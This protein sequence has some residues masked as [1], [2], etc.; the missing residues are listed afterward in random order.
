MNNELLAVLRLYLQESL[1]LQEKK[2]KKYKK[3][4]KDQDGDGNITRKDVLLAR[5]VDLDES[6]GKIRCPNCSAMNERTRSN[7]Y[8]C[9]ASLASVKESLEEI[10]GSMIELSE[11]KR[12]K[13]KASDIPGYRS[14]RNKKQLKKLDQ[15]TKK[16]AAGKFKKSD[17]EKEDRRRQAEKKKGEET[18]KNRFSNM[19]G[20][21]KE[22]L[23]RAELRFL[24]ETIAHQE[25]EER[26]K[27]RKKKKKKSKTKKKTL[28]KKTM[29]TLKRKAKASGYTA[30]SLASEYRKGLGAFYSSG[31]RK[32]MGAHQW[33]MARVN[34]AIGKRNPSWANLKKSKAK[35]K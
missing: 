5:G 17:Y 29:D 2:K 12:E 26:K 6:S 11:K 27:K 30:G 25:L 21:K 35:K 23:S 18:Q 33:A 20:M 13:Q 32:G 28:S 1:N 22:S 14:G 9:G 31:S 7:C 8:N 15:V 4:F 3:P 16:A 10:I 24:L 34:S 19:F